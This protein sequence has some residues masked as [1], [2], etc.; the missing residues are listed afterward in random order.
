MLG[1]PIY[2]IAMTH[3]LIDIM[4]T[5]KPHRVIAALENGNHVPFS[6]LHE[7][8]EAYLCF[9]RRCEEYF[10]C[11]YLPPE[12]INSV[13][14]HIRL[15]IELYLNK[16]DNPEDRYL[17][18]LIFDCLLKRESCITGC[19]DMSEIDLLELGSYTELQG[20]NIQ[21]PGGYS[22]ILAPITSIIPPNKIILNSPVVS[23]KWNASATS[24]EGPVT[25]PGYDSGIEV[26][27][28]GE[29][30]N[31]SDDSDKTMT[32]GASTPKRRSSIREK[33]PPQ[34]NIIEVLCE[35]GSKF[36]ASHVICAIP[37]GVLK[38][39][40]SGLFVPK[41]PQYKLD[42]IKNLNFGTVNKI[43]LVYARSFL[44]PEV[45]EVMLLWD[46]AKNESQAIQD[47]WYKKIY[48]FS[49]ISDTVV[50]GWIS[51]AAAEY[52][53][54]LTEAE[55]SEKCTLVLRKFLN[56]PYIPLPKNC[57]FSKWKSRKFCRGSYT[58]IAVGA[59][60][61]DI[62][63]IAQPLFTRSDEEKVTF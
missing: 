4:H 50:L 36:T 42:S 31:E 57:I 25:S 32:D 43:Y 37:L 12:G 53:E 22:S 26:A 48:S 23:I 20:G 9:L 41:L 5:P 3:G 34:K 33:P 18:Q 47:T 19:D 6:L 27:A 13:G 58:S 51:G 28:N 8:Y 55:V 1:N 54:T 62:E 39:S 60:Q 24:I 29:T 46:A 14:E 45:S 16:V 35:D 44:H 7:I 52:M 59:S 15:E 2:E 40:G 17:R 61:L 49:K 10:L 56:D 30:G 11:Q 63:Q 38:E 21:L